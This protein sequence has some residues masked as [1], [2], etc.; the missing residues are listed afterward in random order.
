ML[1]KMILMG[2]MMTMLSTAVIAAAEDVYVT[3]NG[4]KY[5]KEVCRFI[6]NRE[7]TKVEEKDAIAKG[8][9]KCSKCFTDQLSKSVK[10]EK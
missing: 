10:G 6:K 9:E 1:K 7:V 8:L 5:H 4:K 3:A 2:L